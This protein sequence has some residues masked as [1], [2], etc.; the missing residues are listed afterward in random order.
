ML[1]NTLYR[2]LCLAFLLLSTTV[3]RAQYSGTSYVQAG[4]GLSLH[5]QDGGLGSANP[6]FSL[7][8]GY[9]FSQRVTLDVPISYQ[10]IGTKY[11]KGNLYSLQPSIYYAI[12]RRDKS[13]LEV[14]ATLGL[15]YEVYQKPSGN[16]LDVTGHLTSFIPQTGIALRYTHLLRHNLGISAMYKY[17]HQY[18]GLSGGYHSIGIALS[19]YL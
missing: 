10:I 3:V 15:G 1:M 17:V 2:Y 6:S 16:L 14:G 5:H 9:V 19:I 11:L 4:G 18:Q 7:S 13:R 12:S 8:Y